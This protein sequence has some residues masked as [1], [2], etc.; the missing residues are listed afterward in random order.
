MVK[1]S[2]NFD[3]RCIVEWCVKCYKVG[4]LGAKC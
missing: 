1:K 2:K 4:F 3:V